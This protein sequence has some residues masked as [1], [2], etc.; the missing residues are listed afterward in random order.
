MINKKLEEF[1]GLRAVLAMWVVVFH[2]FSISGLHVP[3]LLDGGNAVSV[4]FSHFQAL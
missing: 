4:F 3:A 2:V 1:E